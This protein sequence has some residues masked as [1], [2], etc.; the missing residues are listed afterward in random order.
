[1]VES[2]ECSG[3]PTV[4]WSSFF[5]PAMSMVAVAAYPVRPNF[6]VPMRWME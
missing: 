5:M 6:F 3:S 2:A 4:Y 1:M